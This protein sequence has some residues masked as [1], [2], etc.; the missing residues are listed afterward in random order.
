MCVIVFAQITTSGANKVFSVKLNQIELNPSRN[1]LTSEL[2]ELCLT[3]I[4]TYC[5][6]YCNNVTSMPSLN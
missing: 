3:I 1:F 2:G 4:V 5:N 6:N